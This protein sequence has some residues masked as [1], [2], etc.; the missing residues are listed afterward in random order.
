MK[1]VWKEIYEL[2]LIVLLSDVQLS[3]FS[4]L[5]LHLYCSLWPLFS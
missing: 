4:L 5:L 1:T 3:C 2:Q